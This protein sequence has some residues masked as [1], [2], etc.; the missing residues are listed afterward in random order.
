MTTTTTPGQ[1]PAAAAA[2]MPFVIA[3]DVF[4]VYREGEV[5]TVAL[6][7]ASM[8]VERGEF[9]AIVG[10]SGSGKSTLLNIIGGLAET[11]AGRVA[12]A[13]VDLA[14]ADEETRAMVRSKHVGIVFQ[15]DNLVPF[16]TAEEN[17]A[18]PMELAGRAGAGAR[19]RQLLEE[20]GVGPRHG[21]R[22]EQLSG[23]EKQR[24]AIA[25]AI[26]NEPELLLGDELTGEL[27]TK[28]TD[29][30][31]DALAI[32]N[33]RGMTLIIVTHNMRVARRAHR[34]LHI[35]DGLIEESEHA[36]GDNS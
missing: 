23:G 16:L 31:L 26:A 22:P 15:A 34:I 32:L 36:H 28:N 27:D 29:S 9:V 19:A 5:E 13:G 3:D 24:V 33:Q 14:R 7:G 6:R 30:V 18:L 12:V 1:R 21:H 11:T 17:V 35:K 25:T 20:L 2:S 10:R 8:T 4:K